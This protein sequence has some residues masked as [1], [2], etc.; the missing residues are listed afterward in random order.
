MLHRFQDGFIGAIVDLGVIVVMAYL[1]LQLPQT[2]EGL[3]LAIGAGAVG[4]FYSILFGETVFSFLFR[5]D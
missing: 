2:D 1:V 4:V 3:M 5:P